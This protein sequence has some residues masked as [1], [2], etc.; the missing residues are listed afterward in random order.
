MSE[1]SVELAYRK[2][3]ASNPEGQVDFETLEITHSML[4]KRYLIVKGTS[5]LTA[6]LETGEVVTFEPS[7]MNPVNA[8]NNNDLDQQATFTLPDVGNQ[9][10]D[11]MS[12]IPLDNQEWPVFT[13]RQ[14][15]STDLSYPCDGP[16]TYDLQALS[17]T[18]G[19]FTAE[20]GVPRLNERATG[21]LAT[22]EDIPLL[23]GILA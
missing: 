7:P 11:E 3:L 15:I 1:E 6:T 19:L 5:P 14:Y 22:P 17:Q 20:V 21:L 13:Y 4:S 16:V 10:D 9:L 8:A 2:K 23:R 18:K 12:R